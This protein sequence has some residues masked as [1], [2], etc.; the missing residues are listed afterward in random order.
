[1]STLQYKYKFSINNNN[2]KSSELYDSVGNVIEESF[3]F[4]EG[5][6]TLVY[7]I[8]LVNDDQDKPLSFKP[9]YYK[10][11]SIKP[12]KTS[13]ILKIMCNEDEYLDVVKKYSRDVKN[14]EEIVENKDYDGIYKHCNP[15]LKIY[16]HGKVL[17][18]GK[19]CRNNG[20]VKNVYFFITK[21]YGNENRVFELNIGQKIQ[22]F[23]EFVLLM[24][25]CHLN[26]IV[27]YDI[28]SANIGFDIIDY[29]EKKQPIIIIIDYDSSLFRD[30]EYYKNNHFNNKNSPASSFDAI[31]SKLINIKTSNI[32]TY[33]PYH[34]FNKNYDENI[35]FNDMLF[36][37]LG[38]LLEIFCYFFLLNN[39][40]TKL[41]DDITALL[42]W[43]YFNSISETVNNMPLRSLY[44]E[45]M[46]RIC[47]AINKTHRNKI[48]VLRMLVK[49]VLGNRYIDN[50]FHDNFDDKS[51]KYFNNL[52]INKKDDMI[53]IFEKVLVMDVNR[54][55]DEHYELFR[56]EESIPVTYSKQDQYGTTQKQPVT[57][58]GSKEYK[59]SVVEHLFVSD[60][61]RDVKNISDI[62]DYNIG[63]REVIG[64]GS[65]SIDLIFK[66]TTFFDVFSNKTWM[67]FGN[68]FLTKIFLIYCDGIDEKIIGLK[69]QMSKKKY[70]HFLNPI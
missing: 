12:T 42:S 24:Q 14:M 9:L 8:N 53:K 55:F 19:T 35:N 30:E 36:G 38:G 27:V 44:E 39:K 69:S 63:Y 64:G 31:S 1:M 3:Y 46:L 29:Q 65:K 51:S 60:D 11:S 40:S 43:E 66:D 47:N 13:Y 50:Y 6:N 20:K 4:G 57:P 15:L 5:A 68:D 67:L 2:N 22:A 41:Y 10:P 52:L 61:V 49:D 25:L 59:H 37:T 18:N 26:H 34:I 62:E 45:K 33:I 21:K 32:G 54:L 58:F 16:S 56:H 7:D 17:F 48:Y 23:N 28:K 70:V